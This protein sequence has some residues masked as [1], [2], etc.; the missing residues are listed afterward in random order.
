MKEER[1]LL[2]RPL[3]GLGSSQPVN[4]KKADVTIGDSNEIEVLFVFKGLSAPITDIMTFSVCNYNWFLISAM[5][6]L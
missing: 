1:D 6:F 2:D 4:R 3:T 5:R